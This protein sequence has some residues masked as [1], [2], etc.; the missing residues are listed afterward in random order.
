MAP[1]ELWNGSWKDHSLLCMPF[2]KTGKKEL[3]IVMQLFFISIRVIVLE[4]GEIVEFGTPRD[5]LD[6]KGNG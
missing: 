4:V 2:S 5:L 1:L 3:T 6:S